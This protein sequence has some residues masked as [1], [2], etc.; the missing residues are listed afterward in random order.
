MNKEAEIKRVWG[1]LE[2]KNVSFTE[3]RRRMLGIMKPPTMNEIGSKRTAL[4]NKRE[5]D[6]VIRGVG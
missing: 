6:R 5:I 4:R 2:N 1:K 3:F